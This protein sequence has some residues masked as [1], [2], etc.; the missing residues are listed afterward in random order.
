MKYVYLFETYNKYVFEYKIGNTKNI[1]QRI[2]GL[3]TG[4]PNKITCKYKFKSNYPT[5]LEA[6]L[7]RIFDVDN[8][9]G[10]WFSLTSKQIDN[11]EN[12]CIS[13]EKGLKFLKDSGNP[14]V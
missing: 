7:Q 3:Q 1:K 5:K 12:M 4:N 13:Y 14:F 8:L 6:Y 10:E 2:K 11:F 9:N